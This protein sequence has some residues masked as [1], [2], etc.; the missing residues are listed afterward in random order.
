MKSVRSRFRWQLAFTL[1]ELLVVIAIIG[2]LVAL[3]L[4]AVQAAREA[5]RRMQCSNNMHQLALAAH[6]YHDTYKGFPP[7]AL[8]T[9]E[10]GG[11]WGNPIRS[12]ENAASPI[13]H[14]LPFVEQQALWNAIQQPQTFNGRVWAPGGGVTWFGEY[15]LWWTKIPSVMCPSDPVPP[16]KGRE[17]ALTNYCFSRG[18]KINRVTTTC[19]WEA[20]W[21]KPRGVFQGSV[22]WGNGA[23]ASH[24]SHSRGGLVSIASILD[25]TSNTIAISE[26]VTYRGVRTAIKGS[27][28]MNV[29]IATMSSTPIVC[30]GYKGTNG[31]LAGCTISDS[32]WNR[33]VGWAAGYFLHTGF[34]TV[35]PPNGPSCSEAKGEWG[36]G[37]FP[38]QSYHPGGVNAAM[39]DGSVRFIS[40]TIDTGNLA[41]P[42]PATWGNPVRPNESPYGVWGRLGSLDGGE[43]IPSEF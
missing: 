39:S 9:F 18:D 43:T 21:N 19:S 28:C 35:I 8:G 1:V 12:T 23:A 15:E 3:L 34:N 20:G 31:Q 40:E 24:A 29:S 30:M 38:P 33:G 14:M 7:G 6:N 25:G 17:V 41:A 32:H 36:S 10:P 16:A 37:L 26:H 22:N 42:E 2:V 11:G 5:A 27:Y 4:P 13:Y